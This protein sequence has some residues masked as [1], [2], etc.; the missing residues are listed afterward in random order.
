MN[1]ASDCPKHK[2]RPPGLGLGLVLG[3]GRGDRDR[4]RD[5]EKDLGR[6]RDRDRCRGPGQDPQRDPQRDPPDHFVDDDA[7]VMRRPCDLKSASPASV[8]NRVSTVLI[9]A[10]LFSIHNGGLI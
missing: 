1:S 3:R 10:A 8:A 2:G 6:G 7:P 9:A 4:D 5:R